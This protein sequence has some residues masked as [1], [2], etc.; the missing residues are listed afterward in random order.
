M[1]M[2]LKRE[3]SRLVT[4]PATAT[5]LVAVMVLGMPMSASAATESYFYSY[6]A[7]EWKYSPNYR[8]WTASIGFGAELPCCIIMQAKA[9]PAIAE[10]TGNAFLGIG[11]SQRVNRFIS[12]RWIPRYYNGPKYTIECS[13]QY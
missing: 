13:G 2:G 3:S 7:S 4:F 9:G 8:F 11:P 5:L 12:C 1:T 6:T 10:A